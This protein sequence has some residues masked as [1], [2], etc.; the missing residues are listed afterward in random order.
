MYTFFAHCIQATVFQKMGTKKVSKR[1][2][3]MNSCWC[4][5]GE[6]NFA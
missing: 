6:E 5:I 2:G 4:S 1:D 3:Y